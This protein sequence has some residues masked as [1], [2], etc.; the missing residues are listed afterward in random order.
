[1]RKRYNRK[2]R[3]KLRWYETEAAEGLFFCASLMLWVYAMAFVGL[4]AGY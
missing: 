1:M 2:W 4:A 3:T